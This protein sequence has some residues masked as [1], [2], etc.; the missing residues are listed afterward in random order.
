MMLKALY[1]LAQ[2]E[3]LLENPDF[4]KKKVD[5]YL[6][7]D[8]DG[9]FLGL[10]STADKVGRGQVIDV[11]R[12]PKRSSGIAA[13]FLFD[14]A[15]YVLGVGE[16]NQPGRNERCAQAF[17]EHIDKLVTDT[18]DEGAVAVARFLAMRKEQLAAIL[19]A[20]PFG[21]SSDWTGS[22]YIAFR[23]DADN[24]IVHSREKVREYWSA[25]RSGETVQGGR[26]LTCLVTGQESV[27]TRLHPAVKRIPKAQT[28]GATLVSFNSEA[29]ITHGLPNSEN[30]P[31]SRAAAEGYVTALNWMLE[32]SQSPPRRFRYGVPIGDDAVAVFWTRDAN[33]V[34]DEV[35][36]LFGEPDPNAS[37]RA[38]E[39]VTT[40]LENS[41]YRG[42]FSSTDATPFYA[43]T[44]SGNARVIVRDWLETTASAVRQ[45]LE[46]YFQDLHLGSAEPQPVPLRPLLRSIEAPGREVPPMLA[47]RLLRA[48]LRGEP[49][50]RQ[51]L[52]AAL[53]R[54]RLP[55]DKLDERRLLHLR[56][57]LIKAT[58][59]RLSPRYRK[60]VS[61]SLN[62][63]N[64]KVPYLLGRLFAVLENLQ[65]AAL[66]DINATIRDRFFGAASSTP[67]TVF[68]R[69]LRLSVHHAAKSERHD[70][71]KAKSR[72]VGLLPAQPFPRLLTLEDQGLFAVGYYHQREKLFEKKTT[73][74]PKAAA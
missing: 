36:E 37:R 60:E 31:I 42:S 6:R 24:S 35:M 57:A 68:P 40:Q 44:L 39:A 14:N 17:Q 32:A 20:Y 70:L 58:L 21:S 54:L 71:E 72:I 61:V 26:K 52:S 19:A 29:F 1:E 2:R 73:Q 11:P 9:K 53:N 34:V 28:S 16:E 38:S 66:G 12:L 55:P 5:I 56:C 69:L 8:A 46:Q 50:P 63:T 4:E 18:Q 43:V 45:N 48:A 64:D 74:E 23:Y 62:E 30:A 67:A 49:F 59:L 13:G 22:E 27:P 47:T 25:I 41:V 7:I 10:E 65:A 3:G 51:L 33:A 15:Q